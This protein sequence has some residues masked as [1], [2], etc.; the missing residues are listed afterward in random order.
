MTTRSFCVGEYLKSELKLAFLWCSFKGAQIDMSK[1]K[2]SFR[3][4]VRSQKDAST[5]S[6]DDE[7]QDSSSLFT[8]LHKQGE[9]ISSEEESYIDLGPELVDEPVLISAKDAQPSPQASRPSSAE[10]V[11]DITEMTNSYSL[12][13]FRGGK[14]LPSIASIKSTSSPCANCIKGNGT[15]SHPTASSCNCTTLVT[16]MIQQTTLAD[17]VASMH[18]V[19]YYILNNGKTMALVLAG[20]YLGFLCGVW[21]PLRVWA[22]VV[23]EIGVYISIVLF[24]YVVGQYVVRWLVFPGSSYKIQQDISAEFG[25]YSL[26]VLENAIQVGLELANHVNKMPSKSSS[27]LKASANTSSKTVHVA[28]R[29]ME[30]YRNRIFVV[31]CNVLTDVYGEEEDD[32]QSESAHIRP[33]SKLKLYGNN[34]I[35]G[36]IRPYP[37]SSSLA[38][39]HRFREMSFPA[40]SAAHLILSYLRRI[41]HT[42][43]KMEQQ[44]FSTHSATAEAD[45]LNNLSAELTKH[46]VALRSTLR[47]ISLSNTNSDT[48]DEEEG[49]RRVA[50]LEHG[51]AASTVSTSSTSSSAQSKYM[52]GFQA[53]T[54]SLSLILDPFFEQANSAS[55]DVNNNFPSGDLFNMHVL[56]GTFLSRYIGARQ[57]WIPN[58]HSGGFIDCV[59]IP[60]SPQSEKSDTAENEPKAVLYC[61]PNAGLYEVAT[62]MNLM[63][64]NTAGNALN[65][66]S[67]KNDA[68]SDPSNNWTDFYLRQGY[69]VVLFNYS[70]YGRSHGGVGCSHCYSYRKGSHQRNTQRTNLSRIFYQP[71][72]KEHELDDDY[73]EDD[74]FDASP[75]SIPLGFWRNWIE[76]KAWRRIPYWF[77]FGFKV[78][79]LL[80]QL[81]NQFWLLQT[82]VLSI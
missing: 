31:Y 56:R 8:P 38:D 79:R 30:Q 16:G 6:H 42:L 55:Y 5:L 77:C 33:K 21:F 52:Q 22:F 49:G 3:G 2:D 34:P 18:F 63:G 68:Q 70:G 28:W 78:R 32:D 48:A 50:F 54:K 40:A 43:D 35:R 62:G 80:I 58:S 17:Y 45:S 14:A 7:R 59:V 9:E 74:V 53:V 75:R 24:V 65:S 57:F 41:I 82:H 67:T 12:P 46:C 37:H 10:L 39:E 44:Y 11:D 23:T 60:P 25:K 15:S 20:L 73:E 29:R 71:I 36:D 66:T 61:N 27:A 81:R 76:R 64:G 19:L 26:R 4:V 72:S 51:S 47:S 1:N 13:T 69:H